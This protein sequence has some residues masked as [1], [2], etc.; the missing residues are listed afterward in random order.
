MVTKGKALIK[1]S[2]CRRRAEERQRKREREIDKCSIEISSKTDD[3]KPEKNTGDKDKK[4]T[5][6][7]LCMNCEL[8]PM[9]C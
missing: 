2:N 3:N 5:L 7:K 9:S 6:K 4:G 8:T 1:Y